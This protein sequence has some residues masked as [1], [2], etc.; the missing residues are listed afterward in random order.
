MIW[1]SWIRRSLF[2]EIWKERNLVVF[3]N[4]NPNY[5][6]IVISALS[7]GR[8]YRETNLLLHK[9]SSG[10]QM[11][12]PG[13]IRWSPRILVLSSS[14]LMAR[15]LTSRLPLVLWLEMRM[16]PLSLLGRIVLVRIPL[17]RRNVWCLVMVSGWQIRGDLSA[18]LLKAILSWLS[19]LF[20]VPIMFLET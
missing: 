5:T 1:V 3:Q 10:N 4:K 19:R 13:S 6:R 15:W 17:M 18:S 7:M 16:V 11:A 14:T 20:A 9:G 12:N 8:D 2:W